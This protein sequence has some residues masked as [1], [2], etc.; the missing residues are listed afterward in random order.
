MRYVS[1]LL[2]FAG[3]G[4]CSALLVGSNL[5]WCLGIPF[6]LLAAVLSSPYR[7]IGAGDRGIC[8]AAIWP[9]AYFSA[10]RLDPLGDVVAICTGGIIG[11]LGAAIVTGFAF[12]SLFAGK[13]LFTAGLLGGI[14]ALPLALGSSLGQ[15][16][17]RV[18]SLVGFA[19]WQA[20]VGTY[21]YIIFRK[22]SG[23]AEATKG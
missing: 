9:V 21:L 12:S 3:C 15:Y 18:P 7:P 11:G 23:T 14:A 16:G 5:I 22:A 10:L 20:V 17:E 13:Y 2:L 4:A 1:I 6:A 19:V 8:Y